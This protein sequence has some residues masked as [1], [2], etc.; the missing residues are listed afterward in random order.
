MEIHLQIPVAKLDQGHSI[1]Q[2]ALSLINP[3]RCRS[4]IDD[5]LGKHS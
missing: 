5:R 1:N 4:T 2:K 3:I